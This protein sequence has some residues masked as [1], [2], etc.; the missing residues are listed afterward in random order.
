MEHYIE[1]KITT[2][3]YDIMHDPQ[4]YKCQRK[5]QK[6]RIDFFHLYGDLKN[7]SKKGFRDKFLSGTTIK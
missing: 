4:T 3:K 1:V 5:E 7:N 2:A 6:T